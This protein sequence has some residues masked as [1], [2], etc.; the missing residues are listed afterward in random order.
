MP[1]QA[2]VPRDSLG[3]LPTQRPGARDPSQCPGAVACPVSIR[4][5]RHAGLRRLWERDDPRRMP[6]S[7]LRQIH[8]ILGTLGAAAMIEDL[9][10]MPRLYPLHGGRAGFWAVRVSANWRVVFR[11]EE[12]DALDVDLI[13]CHQGARCRQHDAQAP[14]PRPRDPRPV[15]RWRL[16][17]RRS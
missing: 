12:S 11:F 10:A 7:Y 14:S 9:A 2:E 13:D 17:S 15:A 1:V 5:F 4:S 16:R 8:N 6:P 3:R